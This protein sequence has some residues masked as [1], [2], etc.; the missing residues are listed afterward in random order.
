MIKNTKSK[1][2]IKVL[3]MSILGS[4]MPNLMAQEPDEEPFPCGG[5]VS[6]SYIAPKEI[7]SNKLVSF[8]TKF[9]LYSGYGWE[10]DHTYW[11]EVNRDKSGK[12]LLTE[13]YTYHDAS[14]ETNESI[15][16]ELQK[17]IVKHDL[18][19]YNGIDEYTAGLPEEYQPSFLEANY[20]SGENL[21]FNMDNNPYSK[22]AQEILDLF[23]N[24]FASHGDN[25]F[26]PPKETKEIVRF[27]F[28]YSDKDKGANYME[29]KMPKKGSH[30]TVEEMAEGKTNDDD[31]FLVVEKMSWSRKNINNDYD[32]KE[33]YSIPNEDYYT[34]LQKILEK[35][36]LKKYA[37]ND[38]FPFDYDD[39][40]TP[41]H[42]RFY[43]EFKYGNI[44]SGFSSDEKVCMEFMKAAKEISDYIDAFI[45]K[46]PHKAK[47]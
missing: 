44:L 3:I 5:E 27:E 6:H 34:G 2:I 37:N 17:I 31:F 28:E 35:V 38:D 25:R 41:Y 11:F 32:F 14:C 16:T 39:S 8:S 40:S 4:I 30:Y 21:Y 33:A 13:T 22:W 7:K 12:L 23:A 1:L 26:L 15:L 43:V 29:V 36:N 20:D 18:V 47:R 24:E 10:L 19:E 9:F 42:Y 45:A 46:N